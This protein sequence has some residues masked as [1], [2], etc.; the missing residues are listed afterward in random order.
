[1]GWALDEV[2]RVGVFVAIQCGCCLLPVCLLVAIMVRRKSEQEEYA[3]TFVH[4]LDC[5]QPQESSVY[6][7]AA[8][9]IP[10]KLSEN[11][12]KLR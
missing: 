9:Q 1:M 3:E 11:L 10:A 2:C 8:L 5:H 7:L 4:C 6:I 12:G